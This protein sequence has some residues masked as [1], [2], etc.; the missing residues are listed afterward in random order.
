VLA[1]RSIC[2]VAAHITWNLPQLRRA[3]TSDD[4]KL[5]RVLATPGL[6]DALEKD[7]G[8]YADGIDESTTGD[9]N[10]ARFTVR[11]I[12]WKR[13]AFATVYL[14]ALDNEQH[15]SGPFSPE[16]IV[17]LE[18]I[19]A[20]LGQ[21]LDSIQRTYVGNAVVCIIS[22]HGFVRVDKPST[23]PSHSAAQDLSTSMKR[24]KSS[25]GRL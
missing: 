10:R 11:L 2:C 17:S 7:L 16:S 23:L 24:A 14:N 22:D 18:R 21:I 13:P 19:D 20:A 12:E 25:P 3:G 5:L 9:K 1:A 8:P 15:A 4:R 6:L